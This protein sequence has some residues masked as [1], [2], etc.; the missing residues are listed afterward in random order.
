MDEHTPENE[1]IVPFKPLTE[2]QLLSVQD[3]IQENF[4]Q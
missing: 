2:L 1:E 4:N 3:N